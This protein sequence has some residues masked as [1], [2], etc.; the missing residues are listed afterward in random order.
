MSEVES[1]E[2]GVC[3]WGPGDVGHRVDVED[4]D[5]VAGR[6]ELECAWYFCW[7]FRGRAVKTVRWRGRLVS[8]WTMYHI[9]FWV[10][11]LCAFR[12]Q[13]LYLS[14]SCSTTYQGYPFWPVVCRRMKCY[15]LVRYFEK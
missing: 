8:K 12:M 4:A 9:F 6:C 11:T 5:D 10:K 13:T 7:T 3:R 1:G 15:Y 14:I 2:I